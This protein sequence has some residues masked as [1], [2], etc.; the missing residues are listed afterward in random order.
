VESGIA[1]RIRNTLAL[2]ARRD[3][4]VNVKVLSAALLVLT[5]SPATMPCENL[6]SVVITLEVTVSEEELAHFFAELVAIDHHSQ[7]CTDDLGPN[8]IVVNLKADGVA[9]LVIC[10]A[11]VI[12]ASLATTLGEKLLLGVVVEEDVDIALDFLGGRPIDLAVL[13][14]ALLLEDELLVPRPAA[15]TALLVLHGASCVFAAIL[16]AHAQ[17][18]LLLGSIARHV[19]LEEA[20]IGSLAIA[21]QELPL[22]VTALILHNHLLQPSAIS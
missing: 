11:S 7:I 15:G 19:N 9:V 16:L 2:D 14:Q 1:H 10:F 13:L 6:G 17:L 3:L 8:T 21:P 12:D 20:V 4:V 18:E 22:L 5:S